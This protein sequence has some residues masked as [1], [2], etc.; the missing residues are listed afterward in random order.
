MPRFSD[1]FA[2]ASESYASFRPDYPDSLFDWLDTLTPQ[3]ERA[4]DCGTGSGQ[5]A[6]PLA[7][8]HG[9]V[10]ASDPSLRQL[11]S[12]ARADRVDYVAM[13][14]EVAALR[15]ESIDLVTVAQALHWFDLP[16]FFGEVNRVLRPG[17]AIAVWS[18]GLLTID[19][20]TDAQLRHLYLDTL[21]AYWPVERS[22]VDSGYAGIA[23]PYPELDSPDVPM[24]AS[25]TLQQLEGYLS[26]WSAVGRYR[27]A[28][29]SD[30]VPDVI[31][32]IGSSWPAGETRR[33]RWPLVVRAARKNV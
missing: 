6:V 27:R 33:I 16:R 1:H 23:L 3:H 9:Q 7:R 32:R 4:W 18:Y 29:G 15:T 25:W 10:I 20:A 11:A 24:E 30:P 21:G 14:A 28:L 12:A 8:R 13:S 17:G 2:F 19:P 26:T 31:R 5:A 22:L